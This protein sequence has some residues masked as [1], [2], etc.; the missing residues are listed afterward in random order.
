MVIKYIYFAIDKT[1][2]EQFLDWNEK[3]GFN[4]TGL[5]GHQEL[6]F[7]IIIYWFI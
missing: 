7:I 5:I 6:D 2:A 3:H 1:V 4:F